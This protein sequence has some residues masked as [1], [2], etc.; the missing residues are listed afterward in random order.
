[1][2]R[3]SLFYFVILCAAVGIPYLSNEW[4]SPS[5]WFSSHRGSSDTGVAG[6]A[7]TAVDG[8]P[9][10]FANLTGAG[11]PVFGGVTP[12]GP[13]A[14]RAVPLV[15]IEECLR[16]DV[17]AAWILGR[18]P[19][20]TAGLPDQDLQGYRVPLVTGTQEDDLA[21]SL[22]YYFNKHQH[23]Q[24]ITF[25]GTTGDARKL[26]AYLT[27]RYG[28]KQQ[29]SNDPNLYL[30][31]IR[32]NGGPLSELHIRPARIVRADAPH[33]RFEVLLALNDASGK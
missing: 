13:D 10:G 24:R 17:T 21:G 19:R 6:D 29:T 20:V 3:H 25:Q 5:N 26:I 1:M 22:S 14:P 4:G 7:T 8:S 27:M 11:N 9:T 23:C 30:Y 15:D 2:F 32:W 12:G 33:A 16:F 18:W 31:Q 28:F